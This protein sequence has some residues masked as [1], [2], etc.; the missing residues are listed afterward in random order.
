MTFIRPGNWSAIPWAYFMR[1]PK[2]FSLL[3]AALLSLC[4]ALTIA[5]ALSWANGGADGGDLIT[6]AFTG[7][8]P[9]PTGYPLYLLVAHL[10]QDFPLGGLAFRTNLLSALCTVLAA[11]LLQSWLIRQLENQKFGVFSAFIGGAA[12]GLAPL[13]WGQAVITE[14]Y[15]LQ[16]LLILA[17]L[18]GL[19]WTALNGKDW[20][21]GL[22]LGL[23]A[24]NHLTSLILI[25]LLALDFS[26]KALFTLPMVFFKR[27]A[28]VL[29]GLS[30]YLILPLRALTQPPVNWGNPITL[31]AFWWLVS[32]RLYA[33]YPFGV[34]FADVLLRLRGVAGLLLAQFALLG[35]VVG[36]Y[37]LLSGLPRRILLASLW[38]FSSFCLFAV[39]YASYDSQVYLIPAFIA[40]SIWLTYGLSDGLQALSARFP[41][42]AQLTCALII[43]LLLARL[44]GIFPQVDA[45]HDL[46]AENFG[47]GF[48]SNAP[49]NA[50]VFAQGDEAV[51]ALW[52]FQ[53]SM[54]QRSDI[55]I[56]SE[57][58]IQY[59]WYLTNLAHTYPQL[60]IPF[61]RPLT[62]SDLLAA[63]PARPAC[64]VKQSA[65]TFCQ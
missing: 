25:P 48:V 15:G 38:L 58:L 60:M 47:V 6:A 9:H 24:S 56:I 59:D 30:F 28:G 35:V 22:L 55:V 46:R 50:L 39:S 5:P 23:A 64:F 61:S 36:I 63:N 65:T 33:S 51:F 31:Q 16:S 1:S 12:F 42:L 7:G 26:S 53:F 10:F 44:P 8:V 21:R 29:I 20:V 52:Y 4:Y 18:F 62:A 27:M 17:F 32:G 54:S 2:I 43:L 14:V 34:S 13:V 41:R 49:E 37:G 45:S 11:L 57:E 40:F 19:D 3:L